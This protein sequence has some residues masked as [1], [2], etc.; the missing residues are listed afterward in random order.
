MKGLPGYSDLLRSVTDEERQRYRSDGV[1]L[2]RNIYPAEWVDFL[3]EQLAD[4]FSLSQERRR[5]GQG[6]HDGISE[7]GASTDMV[8]VLQFAQASETP[9][10]LALEGDPSAPVSGRSIVEMDA[11]SWHQGMR[12]PW[13]DK[14]CRPDQN[15]RLNSTG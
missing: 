9:L 8:P 13:P 4:V 10:E 6:I 12:A 2:L 3:R 1:V 15:P 11:S 7:A 14:S 5:F